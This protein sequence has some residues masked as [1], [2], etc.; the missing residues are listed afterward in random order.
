VL[1]ETHRNPHADR[2]IDWRKSTHNIWRAW[3]LKA[4]R[5]IYLTNFFFQAGF[6]FFT[7]FF[8]VYLIYRFGFTQGNI[9][10]FFGYVGLWIVSAQGLLVRPLSR[11]VSEPAILRVSYIAAAVCLL[12]YL[13]PGVWW[14]LL[15]VV[16]FFAA[17][18]GLSI[19]NLTGLL[20]RSASA[21][22][23]GEVLGI[24]A[25]VQALAQSFPPLLAG[26]LAS[27]TTPRTPILVASALVVCA[28]IVFNLY[29][30]PI[31]HPVE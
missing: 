27:V 29:F 2:V 6:T 24:N 30:E 17:F 18:I 15:F 3:S 14:G 12:L 9:G 7:A 4:L 16:P 5:P 21:R 20:S 19:A 28:G 8:G 25:S 23:Q 22:I 26:V 10:D 13:A 31:A 11:R 1:T